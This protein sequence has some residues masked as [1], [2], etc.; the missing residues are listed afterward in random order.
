[1]SEFF[2]EFKKA[3]KSSNEEIQKNKSKHDKE[4]IFALVLFLIIVGVMYFGYFR[5]YY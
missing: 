2:E 4:A 3:R 1:M 5:Q